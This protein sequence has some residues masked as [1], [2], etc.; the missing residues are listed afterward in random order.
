MEQD[1]DSFILKLYSKF[2]KVVVIVLMLLLMLVVAI[3]V[4]QMIEY[5]YLWI[6][7][8]DIWEELAAVKELHEIFGLF[9][10][11]LIGIELLETIKMYIKKNTIHVEVVFLV[12]M[13]A[14]ARHII[15]L[16][17]KS[18]DPLTILGISAIVIALTFGYYLLRKSNVQKRYDGNEQE[19]QTTS[20]NPGDNK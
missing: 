13:I 17:Y 7:S 11:V 3:S 16:D 15:E 19:K 1:D 8:G 5:M 10:L 9:L 12:A 6:K 4:Y 14:V 18:L 20:D 2:Q